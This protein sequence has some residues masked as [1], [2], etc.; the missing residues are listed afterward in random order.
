VSHLSSSALDAST[1]GPKLTTFARRWF[2]HDPAVYPDPSSFNPDRFLVSTPPPNPTNYIF[3]FGRRICPGRLLAESSVWLTIAKSLAAFNI[4]KGLDEKGREIE[5]TVDF[6][7]GIISHP[8][9]FKATIQP[10]SPKHEEL[11]RAI[12]SEHPWE[13][14]SAEVL[15]AIEV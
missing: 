3:G 12:E 2:C 14:G 13:K 11:I 5:P 4:K 7:P 1:Q 10:R 15:E 9:P 6:L 8:V